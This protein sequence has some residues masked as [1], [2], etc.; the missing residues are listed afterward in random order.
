MVKFTSE[1]IVQ[2]TAEAEYKKAVAEIT[3][4]QKYKNEAVLD[5]CFIKV[6]TKIVNDHR[7][8]ISKFLR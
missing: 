8:N 3:G 1:D 7:G 2:R 4:V 5:M 6:M